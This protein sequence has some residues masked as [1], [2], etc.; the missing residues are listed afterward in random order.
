M[1][2]L[3]LLALLLAILIPVSSTTAQDACVEDYD[4][5]VDYFETKVEPMYAEGFTVEYFNHY[6]VVNV[7]T[8]WVGATED[9]AF[10]YVLVQCGTPVP[11]GFDDAQVIE[12]PVESVIAMST[13][14][15]PHL[16][17]LGVLDSLVGLDSSL[18]V[19][20]PEVLELIDAGELVEVGFGSEVNIEVVLDTEPDVVMAS[21]SGVL[22]YDVHPVLLENDVPAVINAEWVE[23]SPLARAEWIKFTATFFNAEAAANEYFET[24][25]ADYNALVELTADVEDRPTVLT[26]VFFADA[27]TVAGTDSFVGQYI[28]D[29]GAELVFAEHEDVAG[30]A[31]SA[32][33][34]FETVYLD[35]L[36]AD[37]W[38][39]DAFGVNSVDD[40]LALD[41]RYADFVA[42]DEGTVYNN[43]NRVNENGGND[44]YESGVI[45]PHVVLMDL[46]KIFHPDL[47]PDHELVYFKQL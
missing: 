46:I 16:I 18:Y 26:G 6:K 2:H 32:F 5:S 30:N 39:P 38:L 37:Y 20:S 25:E 43:S 45:N 19:N 17:E 34:D 29:A 31:N 42:V 36:E 15:L 10:T 22:D 8:P 3:L 47:L 21:G 35:G 23:N 33:F 12:L 7:V 24:V 1:K 44:I 28:A 14:Q 9:D 4:E 13:T 11:D 41:E 27:W 40:L